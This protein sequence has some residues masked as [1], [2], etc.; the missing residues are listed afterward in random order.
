ML[1]KGYKIKVQDVKQGLTAWDPNVDYQKNATC[2]YEDEDNNIPYALYRNLTGTNNPLANPAQDTINWEELEFGGGGGGLEI[3]DIGIASLPIREEK[4]RRRY[5]NGQL[6]LQSEFVAFTRKL[7]SAIQTYPNIV[8]TEA[9]WQETV[10]NSAFGQCG[11]FVID[12]INGTIRLPKVV[13]IQGQLT[14]A[15]IGDIVDESLP[16]IKG[17]VTSV[18]NIVGNTSTGAFDDSRYRSGYSVGGGISVYS[19]QLYF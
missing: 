19:G 13:K 8:C 9:E 6:I 14:L 3:G 12:N 4:L 7:K 2:Y 18:E 15:N 16:N 5:L 1:E 11:K 10:T 17:S